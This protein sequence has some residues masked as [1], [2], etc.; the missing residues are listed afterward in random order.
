MI[1]FVDAL[2]DW[3]SLFTNGFMDYVK[4][5]KEKGIIRH[6]GLSTHNPK[7]G[8]LAAESGIVEMFLFAANPAFD[9]LPASEDINTIFAEEYDASLMGIT[10]MKG[11]AGGRLLDAKRSPF[12][13]ALTPIQCIHY[14]LTR[15]AAAAR[16]AVPSA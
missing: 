7:I 5:L 10:V 4:D 6:I 11:Y 15:P 13:V 3:N 9:L 1:H 14:V 12:G 2:E 16:P 8:K